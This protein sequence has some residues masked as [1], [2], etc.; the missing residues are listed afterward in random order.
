MRDALLWLVHQVALG[1][2]AIDRLPGWA[3]VMLMVAVGI[4]FLLT[5]I[6]VRR[7]QE[8]GAYDAAKEE[9]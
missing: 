1:M 2:A 5:G 3:F 7:L 9:S 8:L 4:A 6:V